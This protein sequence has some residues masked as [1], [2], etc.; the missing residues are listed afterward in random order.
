MAIAR[1]C[2]RL[3]PVDAPAFDDALRQREAFLAGQ[4]ALVEP[5]QIAV[6]RCQR[7]LDAQATGQFLMS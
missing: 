1:M 6:A 2:R 7:S 4:A 3:T 5:D